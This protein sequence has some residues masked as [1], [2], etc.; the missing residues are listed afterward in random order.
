MWR[1]TFLP[2]QP[3]P[4]WL[5]HTHLVD[6]VGRLVFLFMQLLQP[7]IVLPGLLITLQRLE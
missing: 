2:L 7:A 6:P 3:L 1:I 5:L 4:W